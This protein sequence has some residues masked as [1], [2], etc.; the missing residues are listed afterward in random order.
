MCFRNY[1]NIHTGLRR[2]RITLKNILDGHKTILSKGPD[3][4][5][6]VAHDV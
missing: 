4:V 2:I 6:A 1:S 5:A 3:K